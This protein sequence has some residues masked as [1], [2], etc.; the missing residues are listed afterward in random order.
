MRRVLLGCGVFAGLLSSASPAEA[1]YVK[2]HGC[3]PCHHGHGF[4]GMAPMAYGVQPA[5]VQPGASAQGVNPLLLLELISRLAQNPGLGGGGGGGVPSNVS[6]R[7]D[8]MDAKLVALSARIDRLDARI[9]E[10]R[11]TRI[12]VEQHDEAIKA[13]WQK[14]NMAPLTPQR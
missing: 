14:N 9:E 8:A 11:R 10:N 5:F 6:S 2:V 1:Q 4:I 3:G 13:L 7:L 12:L